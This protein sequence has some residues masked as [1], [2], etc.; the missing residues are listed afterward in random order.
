MACDILL[1]IW[2]HTESSASDCLIKA[3]EKFFRIWSEGFRNWMKFQSSVK[4]FVPRLVHQL[5]PCA[6][7][8]RQES[9]FTCLRVL[10]N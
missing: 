4:C 3:H 1:S 2:E 5:D 9:S 6:L 8:L 10:L 7:N